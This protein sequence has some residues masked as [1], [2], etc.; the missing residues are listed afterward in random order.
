MNVVITGASKGFGKSL[1]EL[2]AAN[3]H[4]L[5][6]CARN[7]MLLN[8]LQQELQQRHPAL[9]IEVGSFDLSKKEQAQLFGKWVLGFNIS[10]DVLINN[11]GSFEP[12]SVYNEPEGTL[13][14]MM[15]VNLYSAYHLTRALVPAM[16]KQKS[17]HIFN[18]CSIAS[19]K[20]YANGGAYS[21]SKFAL[22]GF[23]KNL[24]EEMKPYGIKV[25]GVYP[26]AAYTDSW[27]GSGI[28]PARIMESEDI[29]KMIYAASQLSAAACVEDIILRP[30]LG[31]L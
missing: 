18:M 26:G 20:A 21:I 14:H 4:K 13:E 30:Q 5:Y 8:Q 17:G 22:S 7:E 27:S 1:A 19:L 12:G 23:S 16:M 9:T 11:A 29:A 15:D 3:G 28:D 10:V 6:L 24:R 25:T 2:F 31:D